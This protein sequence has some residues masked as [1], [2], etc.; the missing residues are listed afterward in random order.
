MSPCHLCGKENQENGLEGSSRASR[1][2]MVEA[3]R[4]AGGEGGGGT[5]SDHVSFLLPSFLSLPACCCCVLSVLHHESGARKFL[6][7]CHPNLI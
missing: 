2:S 1:G 6:L 7:P 5:A 3:V 4:E